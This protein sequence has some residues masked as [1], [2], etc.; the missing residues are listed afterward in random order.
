M[1][2]KTI[3]VGIAIYTK[4]MVGLVNGFTSSRSTITIRTRPP[5]PISSGRGSRL[6]AT[7]R[8]I[9]SAM[10]NRTIMRVTPEPIGADAATFSART[11]SISSGV[12]RR[13]S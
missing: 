2:H 10:P 9:I 13:L 11:C 8:A 5:A 6:G 3:K 1:D 12:R 4:V 7:P